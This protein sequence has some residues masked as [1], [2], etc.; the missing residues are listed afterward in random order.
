MPDDQVVAAINRT[1]GRKLARIMDARGETRASLAKTIG[2][3]ETRLAR[4]IKGSSE[5][6]AAE[7]MIAARALCV[8]PNHLTF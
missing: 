3:S 1:I 2:M 4:I 6:T 5:M 7:L 8:T